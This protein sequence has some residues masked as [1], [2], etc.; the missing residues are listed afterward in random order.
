MF[1]PH[2]QPQVELQLLLR[3]TSHA[4]QCFVPAS[5]HVGN[6]AFWHLVPE[7]QRVPMQVDSSAEHTPDEHAR[8]QLFSHWLPAVAH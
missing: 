2:T 8:L 3:Y 7:R 1:G 5:K 4:T 6:A